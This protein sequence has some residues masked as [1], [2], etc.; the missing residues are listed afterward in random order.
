[1]PEENKKPNKPEENKKEG[2][3]APPRE[4]P[5]RPVED[6]IET[7]VSKVNLRE[8]ISRITIKTLT[9]IAALLIFFLLFYLI[10]AN[11]AFFGIIPKRV[12]Y[13]LPVIG[14]YVRKI[15]STEKRIQ[16]AKELLEDKKQ[17]KKVGELNIDITEESDI[18][19]A[20]SK[21]PFLNKLRVIKNR[22]KNRE[23][24]EVW[25]DNVLAMQIY[26]G[27]G[28][29]TA[30]E[31][32]K[33]IVQ[34]INE[35]LN[36]KANFNELLPVIQDDE[37]RA[38]LGTTELFKVRKEDGIFYN[39]D[40]K[41]LLYQWVNNVRVA[42]GAT[43]LE[44]PKFLVE[45]KEAPPETKNANAPVAKTITEQP[46]IVEAKKPVA[47]EKQPEIQQKTEITKNEET[48]AAKKEEYIKKLKAVAAVCEKM[49]LEALIQV[50]DKM[51]KKEAEE[52]LLKLS[53]KKLTKLFT[54]LPPQQ[55]AIYQRELTSG[56]L[57][58]EPE[59]NFKQLV[60]VW[61]KLP[62]EETLAIFAF[63]KDD[64]KRKIMGSLTV[65]KKSRLLSTMQTDDATKFLKELKK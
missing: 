9:Y 55:V 56:K 31:R 57:T 52:I 29:N 36:R 44:E 10:L 22:V 32:A 14:H 37:Y 24:A 34:K 49:D 53:N 27:I 21:T 16:W 19:G 48:E 64:E 30:Y 26:V 8:E 40:S 59:K 17:M 3:P 65:K 39:M 23:F 1:M 62:P 25:I 13:N 18:E 4:R 6:E 12:A 5:Q 28:T 41:K 51:N 60:P 11:L 2:N 54:G 46:K 43:L 15:V 38:L 63:L 47:P 35:Q 7:S 33:Y 50:F 42:L 45:E 58:E 20:I 61:E